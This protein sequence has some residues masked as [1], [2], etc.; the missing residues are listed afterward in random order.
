MTHKKVP[1]TMKPLNQTLKNHI[2]R[3][4]KKVMKVL[5]LRY[6][7]INEGPLQD[8]RVKFH[9][10]RQVPDLNGGYTVYRVTIRWHE[11]F[12]QNK[13]QIIWYIEIAEEIKLDLINPPYATLFSAALNEYNNKVN[14]G[15]TPQLLATPQRDINRLLKALFSEL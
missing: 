12:Q 15:I 10:A 14:Q 1:S 11:T 13:S 4:I 3:T 8:N 5:P 9:V 2:H 6:R 7:F